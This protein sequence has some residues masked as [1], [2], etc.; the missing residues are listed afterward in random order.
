M[1]FDA[2]ACPLGKAAVLVPKM[3]QAVRVVFIHVDIHSSPSVADH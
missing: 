1:S 3:K 2:N